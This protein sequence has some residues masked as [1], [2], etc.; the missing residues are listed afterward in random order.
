MTDHVDPFGEFAYLL[1][2]VDSRVCDAL[3]RRIN[4]S[5]NELRE[6]SERILEILALKSA[7]DLLACETQ[8]GLVR[9][10]MDVTERMIVE[11]KAIITA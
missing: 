1:E 4:P 9:Y 3:P 5:S 7:Y 6:I 11:N 10:L 2:F 8:T